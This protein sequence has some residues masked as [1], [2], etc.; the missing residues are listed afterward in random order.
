MYDEPVYQQPDYETALTLCAFERDEALAWAQRW[1]HA[2][3]GSLALLAVAV[4]GLVYVGLQPKTKPYYIVEQADG[5]ARV[6]GPAPETWNPRQE[7]IKEHLRQF[8]TTLRRVSTDK[9]LMADDWSEEGIYAHVTARGRKSLNEYAEQYRPLQ[10]KEI[11]DVQILSVLP[12]TDKTYEVRWVEKRHNHRLELQSTQAYRGLCTWT[13]Q[14][15]TTE[16]EIQRNSLGIFIDQCF[17]WEK[18]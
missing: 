15:P 1:R 5:R 11:V 2:F 16:A 3:Q 17:N 12:R 10:S 6:L 18:E 9:K 4:L 7:T 14:E 13:K 8:V